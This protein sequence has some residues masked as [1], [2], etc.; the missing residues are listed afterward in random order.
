MKQKAELQPEEYFEWWLSK[1][2]LK[3]YKAEKRQT[4]IEF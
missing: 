4:K 2:S 1:K 3:E